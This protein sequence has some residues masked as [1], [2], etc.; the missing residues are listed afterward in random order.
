MSQENVDEKFALVERV[1]VALNERDVDGYVACCTDDFELVPVTVEIS[2]TYLGASGIRR[3]FAD[4]QDA[5]PS[6]R[7]WAER[8]QV[9][10]GDV[11]VFERGDVSGRSSGVTGEVEF[12]TVYEFAGE[13]IRRISVFL[14]RAEALKAVGLAE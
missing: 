5:A 2:G 6:V 1:L 3:F 7:V 11:L 14:D 9:V 13:R 12:T 4:L 8:L 10:D